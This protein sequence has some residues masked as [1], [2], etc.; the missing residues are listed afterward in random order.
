MVTLL[1]FLFFCRNFFLLVVFRAVCIGFDLRESTLLGFLDGHKTSLHES[2]SS[3]GSVSKRTCL[4]T[5]YLGKLI[6]N[7]SVSSCFID[8]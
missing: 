1:D 7:R 4:K 5:Q 3:S 2:T 6:E 8:I